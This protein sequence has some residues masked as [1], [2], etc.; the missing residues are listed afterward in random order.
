MVVEASAT[1]IAAILFLVTVREAL[2]LP[3]LVYAKQAAVAIALFILAVV[4]ALAEDLVPAEWH[5][6]KIATWVFFLLGLGVLAYLVYRLP[7]RR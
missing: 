7:H 2:K 1:L 6:P 3:A 5:W 4:A